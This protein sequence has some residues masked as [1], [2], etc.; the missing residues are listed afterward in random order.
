MFA[1]FEDWSRPGVEPDLE[2]LI[3]DPIVRLL[4]RRDN[5]VPADLL[6][7]VAQARA[8]LG[9]PATP[10]QTKA[11]PAALTN[12]NSEPDDRGSDSNLN[13]PTTPSAK[14]KSPESAT[15]GQPRGFCWLGL[16]AARERSRPDRIQQAAFQRY[17]SCRAQVDHR[18]SMGIAMPDSERARPGADSLIRPRPVWTC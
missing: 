2:D 16:D 18:P 10:P 12:L 8:H 4:M 17:R 6:E 15:S 3:N 1:R 11:R 14:R 9:Q 13:S 5:L 7:V